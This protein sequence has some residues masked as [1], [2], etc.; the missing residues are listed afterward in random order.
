LNKTLIRVCIS[1]KQPR[2]MTMMRAMMSPVVED[3][4]MEEP[5]HRLVKTLVQDGQS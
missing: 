3:Q 4:E 1:A 5:L 2:T